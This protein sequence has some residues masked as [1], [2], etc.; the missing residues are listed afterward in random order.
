MGIEENVSMLP[1]EAVGSIDKDSLRPKVEEIL[2][3]GKRA[4][5]IR[6]LKYGF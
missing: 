5:E 1:E 6:R 4:F 3:G 2:E